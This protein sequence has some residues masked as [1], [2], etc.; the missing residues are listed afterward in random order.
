M[1]VPTPTRVV[2]V[3]YDSWQNKL[4]GAADV[5]GRVIRIS[6]IPVTIVGVMPR[7]YAFPQRNGV[8]RP[9]H[10]ERLPEAAPSVATSTR[11]HHDPRCAITYLPS[12][13]E[14]CVR[15]T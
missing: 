1:N 4:D 11:E 6:G 3:G 8:W 2:V 9:L 14:R 15:R 5:I 10:L 7:G 13:T 12:E